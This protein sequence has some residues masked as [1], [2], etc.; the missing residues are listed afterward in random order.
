MRC[1]SSIFLP[2]PHGQSLAKLSWSEGAEGAQT[3]KEW[4]SDKECCRFASCP[5]LT[6]LHAPLLTGRCRGVA[7][8]SGKGRGARERARTRRSLLKVERFSFASGASTPV[9]FEESCTYFSLSLSFSLFRLEPYAHRW[10]LLGF[11]PLGVFVRACGGNN[12]CSRRHP[13]Y[14]TVRL[15]QPRGK[16]PG[17][18]RKRQVYCPRG[19]WPHALWSQHAF[20]GPPPGHAARAPDPTGRRLRRLRRR[21]PRGHAAREPGRGNDGLF[22]LVPRRSGGGPPRATFSLGLCPKRGHGP[23]GHF[24]PASGGGGWFCRVAGRV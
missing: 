15:E 3:I 4:Q 22:G 7:L 24:S 12:Y 21:P 18:R 11:S 10:C 17:R 23:F 14:A 9:R 20:F 1:A 5:A 16:Q 2:P 6:H 8:S 13:I 19:A